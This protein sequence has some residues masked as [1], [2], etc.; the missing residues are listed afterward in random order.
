[1]V[2][3]SVR[4]I[5]EE[6]TCVCVKVSAPDTLTGFDFGA[7]WKFTDPYHVNCRIIS[8]RRKLVLPNTSL[9]I[10]K[11]LCVILSYGQI[12]DFFL[13]KYTGIELEEEKNL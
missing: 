1:M 5:C 10:S 6:K 4:V 7:F 11:T 2:I 8:L 9:F 3:T 13:I 12:R